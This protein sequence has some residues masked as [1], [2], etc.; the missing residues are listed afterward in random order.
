MNT[1]Y[2]GL[3]SNLDKPLQQVTTAINALASLGQIVRRSPWYTS[4]A[5]GPANA[6]GTP[7]PD[8]I[9]GVAELHTALDA[10]TLLNALQSIEQTQGRQRNQRWGART[11]DLDILLFNNLAMDIPGLIIPHPRM[12]ERN[13]V[14]VPLFDIAP[15][16]I[17][18]DGRKLADIASALDSGGLEKC[19]QNS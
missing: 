3:G 6:D 15:G 2:I 18:P 7:Q 8:Y 10:C 4:K 1:A 13:F 16:L 12:L 17:L 14:L 5:V 11:L 19:L 9:N